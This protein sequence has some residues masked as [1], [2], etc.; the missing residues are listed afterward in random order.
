[1][2]SIVSPM[3]KT[4]SDSTLVK[5]FLHSIPHLIGMLDDLAKVCVVC[6]VSL[7]FLL[8]LTLEKTHTFLAGKEQMKIRRASTINDH[9]RLSRVLMFSCRGSV[10]SCVR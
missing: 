9:S 1:M 3:I 8:T 5:Q 6:A 2:I 10:Q 4:F 7:R